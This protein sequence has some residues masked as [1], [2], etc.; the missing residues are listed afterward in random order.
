[1][2]HYVK[3]NE[4][5]GETDRKKSEELPNT[6]KFTANPSAYLLLLKPPVVSAGDSLR[7][8]RAVQALCGWFCDLP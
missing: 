3:I 4:Y 2:G 6:R 8:V 7:T 5:G 1:M